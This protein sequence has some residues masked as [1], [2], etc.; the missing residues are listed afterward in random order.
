M[1]RGS[2]GGSQLDAGP[3]VW[4]MRA[5]SLEASLTLGVLSDRARLLSC[6]AYVSALVPA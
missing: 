1:W 6:G 2:E 3:R 4:E 5:D